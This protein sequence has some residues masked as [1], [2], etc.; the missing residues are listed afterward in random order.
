MLK[1]L[2]TVYVKENRD[3]RD[4]LRIYKTLENGCRRK[5]VNNVPLLKFLRKFRNSNLPFYDFIHTQQE[6]A[7][8]ELQNVFDQHE[9]NKINIY[10]QTG[11]PE[12]EELFWQAE[13]H[14]V[15]NGSLKCIW[16]EKFSTTTP[17]VSPGQLPTKIHS[18]SGSACSRNCLNRNISGSPCPP[19]HSRILSTIH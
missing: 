9:L 5:L 3:E 4:P 8:E 11:D 14:P 18:G 10:R 19:L 1:G 2:L 7:P 13:A 6:E 12:L 16:Y 15:T 17:F